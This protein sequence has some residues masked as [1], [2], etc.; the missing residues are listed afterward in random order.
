LVGLAVAV[1]KCDGA[2]SSVEREAIRSYFQ[3][4]AGL[5]ESHLLSV[6]RL[7]ETAATSGTDDPATAARTMPPLDPSDR[8]HVLFV[9]FRVALADGDLTDHEDRG[10]AAAAAVL[11]VPDDDFR[12]IRSHFVAATG[13]GAG[14]DDY[15]TLGVDPSADEARVKERFREVVKEIH[16]D[17]FEH[18]GEE[19]TSV[20]EEKFKKVQ[21]AYER[22]RAG[23][24]TTTIA[25]TRLS[26]CGKCRT[27]S[28]AASD[29]CPRCRAPKF[30]VDGER[31]RVRCPFCTRKNAFP[32]A[33]LRGDVRCGNCKVLL[34][35]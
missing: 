21:E 8:V 13:G 31:A 15:Q 10:L 2:M 28:A 35:R 6:D 18:L 34:V 26:V 32:R 14:S 33:A 16:P 25:P 4:D 23:R 1:A 27:F 11:R 29:D 12:S 30:E 17:R 24:S 3:R 7:I 19:F 9:L 5:P 22:I 20:A